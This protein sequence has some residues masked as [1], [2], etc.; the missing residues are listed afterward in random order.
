MLADPP[1]EMPG[2]SHV[3]PPLYFR[4]LLPLLDSAGARVLR[5]ARV[6]RVRYIGAGKLP[7]Q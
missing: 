6:A 3:L 5:L 2:Y 4:H 7:Q 1:P